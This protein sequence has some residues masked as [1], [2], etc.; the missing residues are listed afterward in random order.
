MLR[1]KLLFQYTVR[2]LIES[3]SGRTGN[4]PRASSL[5]LP[6]RTIELLLIKIE[7]IQE[8]Y[9]EDKIKEDI[10]DRAVVL[11]GVVGQK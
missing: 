3:L 6:Q 2:K 1:L 5:R 9:L 7:N 10:I 4:S 8:R 11:K